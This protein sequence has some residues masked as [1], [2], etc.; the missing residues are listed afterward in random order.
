MKAIG[1]TVKIVLAILIPIKPHISPHEV[2][3]ATQTSLGYCG[4]IDRLGIP[5]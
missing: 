2:L 3:F 1:C 5:R 4:L